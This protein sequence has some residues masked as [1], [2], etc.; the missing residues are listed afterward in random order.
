MIVL[1]ALL[2]QT[3][4]AG[5]TTVLTVGTAVQTALERN[6]TVLTA[7]EKLIEQDGNKSF[8]FAQIFPTV[9]SSLSTYH[10]KDAVNVSNPAFGGEAYNTYTADLKGTQPL[11]VAGA[12]SAGLESAKLGREMSDIDLEIAQR[13]LSVS[14][15][16]LFYTIILNQEKLGILIRTQNVDHELLITTQQRYKIGRSQLVDV[17]QIKTTSAL[18]DAQIA[19]AK[20]Q[21]ETAAAALASALGEREASQVTVKGSLEPPQILAYSKKVQEPRGFRIPEFEKVKKQEAQF[22]DTRTITLAPSLPSI[23]ASGDINRAAFL[24]SDLFNPYSTAWSVGL[25]LEIPIFSGLSSL[26][27]RRILASQATQLDIGES[28]LRDQISLA[29]VQAT[30]NLETSRADIL[31]SEVALDLAKQSLVES[32]KDYRLATIDLLHYLASEQNLLTAETAWRTAQYNHIV[33]LA[34]FM[35]ASGYP[36]SELITALDIQGGSG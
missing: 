19:D 26:A 11:F 30:K 13:D 33:S 4:W 34:Q 6:P 23:S 1:L 8:A 2:T 12:L 7:R 3:A 17:L 24:K 29:Q 28:L 14:V 10:R 27:Q 22:A 16:Q 21:V 25:Q 35:S 32:K 15:I 18:L 5:M 20:N 31:S 36:V 9:S